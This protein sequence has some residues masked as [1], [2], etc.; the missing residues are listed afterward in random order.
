MGEVSCDFAGA[1]RSSFAGELDELDE[2]KGGVGRLD[3]SPEGIDMDGKA[4][5]SLFRAFSPAEDARLCLDPFLIA[6]DMDDLNFPD[7]ETWNCLG[8]AC[9][10]V[11]KRAI[12][13][14]GTTD[15]GRAD[16]LLPTV[17]RAGSVECRN[18]RRSGKLPSSDK[19]T[20]LS[21]SITSKMPPPASR[22]RAAALSA[23]GVLGEVKSVARGLIAGCIKDWASSWSPSNSSSSAPSERAEWLLSWGDGGDPFSFCGGVEKLVTILGLGSAIALAMSISGTEVGEN[24]AVVT[25]IVTVRDL[26]ASLT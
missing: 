4:L 8:P 24:G 20:C 22:S 17:A 23:A 12:D 25:V 11:G 13:G 21:S 5:D 18:G 9:H 2:K 26:A 6:I 16:A 15:S 14:S 7:S 19:C 10:G 3:I 1:S